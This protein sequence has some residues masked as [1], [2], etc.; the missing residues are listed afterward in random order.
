VLALLTWIASVAR[1]DASLVDR[2]WSLM[3]AAP[4]A[5]LR[6]ASWRSGAARGGG[7]RAGGRLGRAP[8][9]YITWRNWGHG[10]DRRYQ[11]IR[12]RNQPNFA[13]KSLYLIFALQMVLAW[14]VSA[15]TL[16]GA[17][18]RPAR[19]ACSTDSASPSRWSASCSRRSATRRWRLQGRPGQPGPGDGSRPVALHAAPEL[20]RRGLLLVGHLAAR[21][22]RRRCRRDLDVLSPLL[23]TV[24]LLKVSGVALLEKDIGERRPAYRDY[25]ART[26][27]FVPRAAARRQGVRMRRLAAFLLACA[28]GV[29]AQAAETRTYAFQA[30][31][32]DK[33]IGEHR[34]T[35]VTEGATRK[36]TSEADFTV[37]F[38][39]ITA[40]H[41]HHH[42]EEQW[43]GECL[44]GLV[45]STDDDG[46]QAS[47]RLVK[48]GDANEIATN[49]GRK[50]EPGC[51]MT[52]AYWNPAI[53]S[54]SRSSEPAVARSTSA[55]RPLQPPDFASKA[56]R[57]RL[58]SGIQPTA[59]GSAWIRRLRAAE[60]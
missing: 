48:T 51:L 34:F 27:A 3:I 40:Y 38:L 14:I 8:G 11:Q 25:I 43:S 13:V 55:G 12:A 59:N 35:V 4:M 16:A 18:G 7:A 60:S 19:S 49:A 28:A 44:A 10:E 20:L 41:Y 9:A 22:G 52:Y 5:A 50:T 58:T 6:D 53:T 45:S 26:N 31:L 54:R 30:L 1:H 32:D 37:K 23:M 15:P 57:S 21:A 29:A 36:V 56:R 47:V 42:A 39:G 33:P 24:L 2:M 17:G 46:K